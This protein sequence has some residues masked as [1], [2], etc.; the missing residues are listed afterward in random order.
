MML[1]YVKLAINRASVLIMGMCPAVMAMEMSMGVETTTEGENTRRRRFAF[2]D[3][4]PA[5]SS[6]IA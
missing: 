2:G 5:N 3:L 6:E 1:G 4:R